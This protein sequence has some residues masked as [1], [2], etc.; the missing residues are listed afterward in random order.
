MPGT[1]SRRQLF[2]REFRVLRG[3]VSAAIAAA[4]PINLLSLGAPAD[5]YDREID[6]ILFRI[7]GA[8]CSDDVQTIVHHEFVR[9][10]GAETAGG[11]ERYAA[12]ARAIW[13]AVLKSRAK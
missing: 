2:N 7:S 3:D 10:F 1:I 13:H 11:R 6:A 5:E 12:P 8:H 9:F 4:D